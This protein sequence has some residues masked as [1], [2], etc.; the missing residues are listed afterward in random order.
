[1]SNVIRVLLGHHGRLLRGA[2]AAAIDREPDL[3]V[4]AELATTDDAVSV[5]L[6]A[7][8]DVA[9][10]DVVLSGVVAVPDL[11][12]ELCVALPSARVLIVLDPDTHAS[13]G[14]SLA[15]LVPRVGLI[16]TEASFDNLV[17]GVR[18]VARGEP[19]VDASLAL[20]VLRANHNPLTDRE[21]EVLR[22]AV[23]G[24]PTTEIAG[25]LRLGAGT[26][27]NHLTRIVAKTGGRTRI[28]AIRIA[29]REGWI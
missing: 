12:H 5:A 13:I 22:L 11:C 26:V 1:M 2:V 18:Q 3:R 15:P 21:R 14:R 4:V 9:V 27:R 19:V 24:A 7:R 29:Q 10:L 17:E 28:D 20:A 16:A 23:A 25:T 6:R 8:P